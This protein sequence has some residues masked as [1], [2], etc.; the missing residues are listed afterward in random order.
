[1]FVL[2]SVAL[3]CAVA[4]PDALA[5]AVTGTISGSVADQQGQLIPGATLTITNEAN[6][7]MRVSVSDE[8]GNFQ[9]TN[10]QPGS[11]TVKV[12]MQ[13]FRT[14]ERKNVVLSAG[15][16]CRSERSPSRSAASAKP[17]SSKRAAAK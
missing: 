15:E 13:S 7:D 6:N 3:L 12:E 5:Q 2:A 8:R 4:A 1:V 17:S 16:G 14:L 9:V 10:L 11:Y